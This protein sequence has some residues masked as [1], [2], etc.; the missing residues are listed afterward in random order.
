MVLNPIVASAHRGAL[1]RIIGP[2]FV[3]ALLFTGACTEKAR[4]IQLGAAQFETESLAAIE[5]IDNLRVLETQ[6]QPLPP[7]EATAL[8]VESIERSTGE[9]S[10]AA[11]KVISEPFADSEGSSEAQWQ[12]FLQ[13]LRVQYSAF[14]RTFASL[15]KGTLFA[16]PAVEKTIPHLDNLV[17]QMA[18]FASSISENPAEFTRERAEIAEALEATR[19]DASLSVDQRRSGLRNLERRLRDVIDAEREATREAIEQ[20]LKS[21]QVGTNLRALLEDYGTLSLSDIADGLSVGFALATDASGQD[22]SSLQARTESVIAEIKSDPQLEGLFNRA[23]VSL[24]AAR[25]QP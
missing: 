11:L 24:T 7:E 16:A 2:V 10:R 4:Y 9:I 3:L 20:A 21:V 25:P 19:D 15:D 12:A 14:S 23:L 13:D 1:R 5:R 6:V 8:F 17:A 22:L 18:A